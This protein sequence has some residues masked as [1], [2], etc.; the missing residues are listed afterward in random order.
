MEETKNENRD[1]TVYY[2]FEGGFRSE[3]LLD[4]LQ[5]YRQNGLRIPMQY[6]G[7]AAASIEHIHLSY[8]IK[9]D[10][11]RKAITSPK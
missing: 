1:R 5:H 11:K 7:G 4:L 8:P 9:P 6:S 3:S 2:L 10:A